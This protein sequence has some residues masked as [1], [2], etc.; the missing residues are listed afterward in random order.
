[1]DDSTSRSRIGRRNGRWRGMCVFSGTDRRR[2]ARAGR[3]SSTPG[4]RWAR[5][6]GLDSTWRPV[7]VVADASRGMTSLAS[8]ASDDATSLDSTRATVEVTLLTSTRGSVGGE[9]TLAVGRLERDPTKRERAIR[10]SSGPH[11]GRRVRLRVAR[12]SPPASFPAPSLGEDARILARVRAGHLT[13][14]AELSPPLPTTRRLDDPPLERQLG[15]LRRDGVVVQL[16]FVPVPVPVHA[17]APSHPATEMNVETDAEVSPDR[18][19]PSNALAYRILDAAFTADHLSTRGRAIIAAVG[20]LAAVAARDA[21]LAP[22]PAPRAGRSPETWEPRPLEPNVPGYDPKQPGKL[23][24]DSRGEKRCEELLREIR[25]DTRARKDACAS[26]RIRANARRRD[27]AAAETLRTRLVELRSRILRD[28]GTGTGTETAFE[29]AIVTRALVEDVWRRVPRIR[30]ARARPRDPRAALSLA[31][32]AR[33]SPP[34]DDDDDD[35]DSA[36]EAAMELEGLRAEDLGRRVDAAETSR[37]MA[38]EAADALEGEI[39]ERVSWE[40]HE[41]G[42]ET[43]DV[44]ENGARRADMERLL[45][46]PATKA[47]VDASM[48]IPAAER[49]R[50]VG[51]VDVERAR[52]TGRD[53]YVARLTGTGEGY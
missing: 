28:A 6:S 8:D 52:R 43:R 36:E 46:R 14:D 27:A 53:E 45:G 31:P 19:S 2:E 50:I 4:A 42:V 17:H 51:G 33:S 32:D 16:R 40:T 1:M 9:R 22:P 25:I 3:A 11:A 5:A 13:L 38:M 23:A 26:L 7:N 21:R 24:Y 29:P 44:L 10:A 15:S 30:R 18:S 39:R 35:D 47:D 37:R 49:L 48:R 12:G 20:D 34:P 41:S